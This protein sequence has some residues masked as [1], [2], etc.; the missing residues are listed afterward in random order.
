MFR[1]TECNTD[2]LMQHVSTRVSLRMF[3]T[4]GHP[5][6]NMSNIHCTV[7]ARL[8]Y[9]KWRLISI[10]TNDEPLSSVW[11]VKVSYSATT[12]QGDEFP[13]PPTSAKP[14]Q[15]Q[16]PT[17][18][19]HDETNTLLVP[20]QIEQLDRQI[21]LPTARLQS[22]F[23]WLPLSP[24]DWI[25]SLVQQNHYSF[26]KGH[27]LPYVHPWLWHRTSQG[28]SGIMWVWSIVQQGQSIA[29]PFPM[30]LC[31]PSSQLMR[32]LLFRH[33]VARSTEHW[34]RPILLLILLDW[35]WGNS[36]RC[37]LGD[38]DGWGEISSG[39]V[40]HKWIPVQWLCILGWHR[41][42][43]TIRDFVLLRLRVGDLQIRAYW[44]ER[45]WKEVSCIYVSGS[46]NSRSMVSKHWG[47]NDRWRWGS[48]TL[49]RLHR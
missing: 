30:S 37:R 49:R 44:S 1:D 23:P 48:I 2:V 38:R 11:T 27:V 7:T 5:F 18:T 43:R 22:T 25:Q 15:P 45:Q 10:F 6:V 46:P 42:I 21:S 4:A 47:R 3:N 39:I 35:V 40:L 12:W 13:V 29:D 36:V 33:L 9:S 17:K 41:I 32:R 28:R 26:S 19:I 14:A 34:R 20:S 8:S 16:T 24:A 31:L